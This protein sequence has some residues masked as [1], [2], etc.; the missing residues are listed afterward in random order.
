MMEFNVDKTPAA[1]LHWKVMESSVSSL[2]AEGV[3][4][5]TIVESDVPDNGAAVSLG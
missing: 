3:T 5:P 2:V 4:T 1:N